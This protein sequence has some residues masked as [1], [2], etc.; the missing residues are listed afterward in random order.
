MNQNSKL[1]SVIGRPMNPLVDDE[2]P[3]N[4]MKERMEKHTASNN[5]S[6]SDDFI[7]S[8]VHFLYISQFRL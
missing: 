2:R 6:S 7:L 8:S 1:G 4:T 5:I 3:V